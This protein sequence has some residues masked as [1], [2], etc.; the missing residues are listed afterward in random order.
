[1]ILT[2]WDRYRDIG[3]LILRGGIGVMFMF[4][5][6]PKISGGPATWVGLGEAMATFGITAFPSFWGFL[7][8]VSEF[9]GGLLLAAGLFVRPA[10]M[11][12]CATMVVASSMHLAQGDGIL[13]AS[14]AIEMG[15]VFFSMLFIG[16][17]R[18]SIDE[19]WASQG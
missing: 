11:M 4:H 12:M 8:A 16:P 19:R 18:Y 6:W 9:F 17:G 14:H 3:L 7:A 2:A 13:G 10:C 15:I 5:G 1:M